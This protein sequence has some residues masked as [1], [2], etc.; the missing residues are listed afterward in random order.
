MENTIVQK[1]SWELADYFR[2]D[3]K[4]FYK[5]IAAAYLVIRMKEEN[6]SGVLNKSM[7]EL[8]SCIEDEQVR[9]FV[10]EMMDGIDA[11]MLLKLF[12]YNVDALTEN[13]PLFFEKCTV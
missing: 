9:S 13:A 1:L 6:I 10:Y 3:E 4:A 2:A 12:E 7:K 8:C 5:S 11:T